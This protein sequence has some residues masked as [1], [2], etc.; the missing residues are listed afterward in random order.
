MKIEKT[1]NQ[2]W[3][4]WRRNS[5]STTTTNANAVP[6]RRKKNFENYKEPYDTIKPIRKQNKMKAH[7]IDEIEVSFNVEQ[8]TAQEFEESRMIYHYTTANL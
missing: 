7:K 2:R 8:C 3:G 1:S 5:T 4:V 6:T